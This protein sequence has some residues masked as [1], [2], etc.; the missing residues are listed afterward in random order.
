MTSPGF[1]GFVTGFAQGLKGQLDRAQDKADKED[2]LSLQYRLQS[3]QK[4]KSLRDEQ[5]LKDEELIKSAKSLGEMA[6]DPQFGNYSIQLLRGGF[7]PQQI[8][9]MYNKGQFVKDNKSTQD[10]T[11][12]TANPDLQVPQ[13]QMKVPLGVTDVNGNPAVVGADPARVPQIPGQLNSDTVTNQ[14]IQNQVTQNNIDPRR[15]RD[16]ELFSKTD[17]KIRK[18]APDLFDDD[19]NA[20]SNIMPDSTQTGYKYVKPVIEQKMEPLNVLIYKLQKAQDDMSQGKGD[21]GLVKDLQARYRASTMAINLSKPVPTT[22]QRYLALNKDGTIKSWFNGQMMPGDD[23]QMHLFNMQDPNKPQLVTSATTQ[24]D[25]ETAKYL[26]DANDK[27]ESRVKDYNT[28]KTSFIGALGTADKMQQILQRNPAAATKVASL[29]T[30]LN[31]TQNELGASLDLFRNLGS[32]GQSIEKDLGDPNADP[33]AIKEKVAAYKSEINDMLLNSQGKS[34]A[35]DRAL[36][37][38]MRSA[39]AYDL[40]AAYGQKGQGLSDKETQRFMTMINGDTP[41]IVGNQIKSALSNIW[42]KVESNRR[43]TKD[44]VEKT[45]SDIT[46]RLGGQ[47]KTGLEVSRI[48]DDIMSMDLPDQDKLRLNQIL[49]SVSSN[50]VANT[51]NIPQDQPVIQPQQIKVN[52]KEEFD[53]LPSGTT[54]IAPDGSIRIKP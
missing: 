15:Q 44:V 50:T 43:S 36:Y 39:L 42:L 14:K 52:S 37:T 48:G 23:G 53:K 49:K 5:K 22:Q 12:K 9:E 54:F 40:A 10:I 30:L 21:P 17:E 46:A 8:M 35:E 3:L 4:Q 7:T 2:E 16:Q 27:F 19:G 29:T 13:T 38:A 24:I 1:A 47:V 26:K 34:L 31:T 32:L 6:N 18:F 20:N 25:D 45:N 41:E 33:D 28:Q 51:I 11:V